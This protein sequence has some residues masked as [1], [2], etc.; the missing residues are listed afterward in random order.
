[1]KHTRSSHFAIRA[2]ERGI[3][4]VD[5]EILKAAIEAALRD[6]EQTMLDKVCVSV[7]GG[8]IYRFFVP[9]GVFYAVVRNG[10]AATVL[11]QAMV[12]KKKWA[13]KMQRRG[14]TRRNARLPRGKRG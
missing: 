7:G 2:R 4:T 5:G 11:T 3:L 14:F 9:D 13:L 12:R 1:M 8:V 6:P 10:V